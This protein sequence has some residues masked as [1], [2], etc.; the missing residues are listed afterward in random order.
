MLLLI[1]IITCWYV[2][3]A[4]GPFY[5]KN[6]S[7]SEIYPRIS[8]YLVYLIKKPYTNILLVYTGVLRYLLVH[9]KVYQLSY[10]KF[11]SHISSHVNVT[12]E[13]VLIITKQHMIYNITK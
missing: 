4:I 7:L 6:I 2:C 11:T 12:R 5:P 13:S 9:M 3:I 10:V 8:K 1:L